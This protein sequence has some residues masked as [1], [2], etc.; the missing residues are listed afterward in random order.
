ML[1]KNIIDRLAL[2]SI[3]FASIPVSVI[4]AVGIFDRAGV[5]IFN[6]FVSELNFESAHRVIY[7][8]PTLFLRL[9]INLEPIFSLIAI[10]LGAV[11]LGLSKRNRS[12][13][14]AGVIVGFIGILFRL[15]SF[16]IATIYQ[17]YY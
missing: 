17:P 16:F 9:L 5:I 11:S 14:L 4:M 2:F 6:N 8:F 12:L 7:T 1:K 10:V 3:L 13:A 15:P